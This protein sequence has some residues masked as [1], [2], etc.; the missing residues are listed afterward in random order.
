MQPLGLNLFKQSAVIDHLI[1]ELCQGVFRDP[2]VDSRGKSFC[3]HCVDDPQHHPVIFP[4]GHAIKSSDM[5]PNLIVKKYVNSLGIKCLHVAESCAWEGLVENLNAHLK[6]CPFATTKCYNNGC[7][8]VYKN[9][10]EQAHKESCPKRPTPC[11]HCSAAFPFDELDNHMKICPL[12]KLPCALGCGVEVARQNL[13]SHLSV[14]CPRRVMNCPFREAG[15]RYQ[16]SR[17]KMEEHSRKHVQHHLRIQGEQIIKQEVYF[18]QSMMVI[19][20]ALLDINNGSQESRVEAYKTLLAQFQNS[21]I[22]PKTRMDDNFNKNNVNVSGEGQKAINLNSGRH[23]MTAVAQLKHFERVTFVY[24]DNSAEISEDYTF[25]VG[26]STIQP[27]LDFSDDFFKT[28]LVNKAA[29]VTNRNKA[30]LKQTFDNTFEFL[31]FEFPL[32]NGDCISMYIEPD[33]QNIVFENLTQRV[34]KELKFNSDFLELH[35]VLVLGPKVEISLKE[36][37]TWWAS[38]N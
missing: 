15:C 34:S 35:L 27:S 28:E 6:T 26:F 13:A 16:D 31:D 4:D 30:Y 22:I 18:N 17:D 32:K 7:S 21:K 29:L 12:K 9:S 38:A 10:E 25:G 14:D 24:Q 36:H 1:C 23:G 11:P 33:F 8:Q 37:L 20:E 3:R 19:T 5:T 2:V